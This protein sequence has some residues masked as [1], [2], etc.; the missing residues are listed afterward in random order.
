M[1]LK[2][3]CNTFDFQQYQTKISNVNVEVK[4]YLGLEV[5]LP[6]LIGVYSYVII[7]LLHFTVPWLVRD[8]PFFITLAPSFYMISPLLHLK[9]IPRQYILS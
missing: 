1:A 7:R 3:W 9:K 4:T 2:I 5:S 6:C 8:L